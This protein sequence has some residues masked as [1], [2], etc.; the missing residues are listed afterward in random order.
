MLDKYSYRA[1]GWFSIYT[2]EPT[3]LPLNFLSYAKLDGFFPYYYCQ[4]LQYPWKPDFLIHV[5]T[6][7]QRFIGYLQPK[8]SYDQ[9]L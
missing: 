4:T 9:D 1:Q 8:H 6:I 7:L 3:R 2:N 5:Y